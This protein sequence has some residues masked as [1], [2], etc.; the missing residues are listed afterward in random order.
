MIKPIW[1][2][3]AGSLKKTIL[4]LGGAR[5]GKSRLALDLARKSGEK[6]LFVATATPGDEEMR[7]RIQNHRKERPSG[8]QTLEAT[9]HLGQAIE[10]RT[11]GVTVVIIDCITLLVS[12][13]FSD[14]SEGEIEQL[15]DTTIGQEVTAEIEEL[16]ASMKRTEATFIVVSNE[17]GLG[18]VPDNRLG[19]LYRDALGKA[20]QMLAQYAQE[21]YLLV[22]GIPVKIK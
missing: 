14:R 22:A 16:L 17:V 8:W 18:L 1:L 13:L 20:N 21:V 9:R 11:D 5:S 12:N 2:K 19:R 15:P 3:G 10:G 6:V 4:L 7:H